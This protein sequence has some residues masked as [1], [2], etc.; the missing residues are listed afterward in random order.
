V[1]RKS[2]DDGGLGVF[3]GVWTVPHARNG[4]TNLEGEFPD[5]VLQFFDPLPVCTNSLVEPALANVERWR[6]SGRILDTEIAVQT[7]YVYASRQLAFSK[8]NVE[9]LRKGYLPPSLGGHPVN[10]LPIECN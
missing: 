4:N 3:V 5:E 2:L 8:A 6:L 1:P 9:D 10:L 7:Y